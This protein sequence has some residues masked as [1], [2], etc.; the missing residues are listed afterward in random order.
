MGFCLLFAVRGVGFGRSF[1]TL[2]R[3]GRGVGSGL[4]LVLVGRGVGSGGPVTMP[5]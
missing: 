3:V 2:F 1:D 5:V 4:V